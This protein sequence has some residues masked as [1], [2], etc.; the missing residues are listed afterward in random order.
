MHRHSLDMCQVLFLD[1]ENDGLWQ[2]IVV[3]E[4]A[5]IGCLLGDFL[6]HLLA[7][8]VLVMAGEDSAPLAVKTILKFS[9][10]VLKDI[11]V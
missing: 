1:I 8:F 10:S 2:R 6:G 4:L 5:G 7:V 11:W 9:R 3:W